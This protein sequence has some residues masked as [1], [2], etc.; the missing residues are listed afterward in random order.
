MAQLMHT[1]AF[2]VDDA[3]DRMLAE[4]ACPACGYR[5]SGDAY[6]VRPCNRVRFFCDCCGAFV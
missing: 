5:D 3:P 4:L 6:R 2:D 1:A